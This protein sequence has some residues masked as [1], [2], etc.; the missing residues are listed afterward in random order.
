MQPL[1][2]I[3]LRS[4]AE[5][6]HYI[7]DEVVSVEFAK[8]AGE[9]ASPEGP[10]GFAPGDAL[11]TGST[12]GRWSVSRS[13]FDAKYEAVPPLLHG[14]N[15]AYRSKRIP[16]LAKQMQEPFAIARTSGGDVIRGKAGDWLMQY[17]PGDYGIV[18]DAKFQ[19]VYRIA[20]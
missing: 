8:I 17:A 20:D 6:L 5:A 15:G 4:D 11:V 10:N 13:R 9:I 1:L 12:G 2:Y 7:K 3:E 14:Q 19:K 18:E 16:V